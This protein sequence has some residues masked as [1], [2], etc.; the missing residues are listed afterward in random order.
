MAQQRGATK[1]RERRA[2]HWS[3][4]TAAD[5]QD[6]V[7]KASEW[8]LQITRP[9]IP[10]LANDRASD[11]LMELVDRSFDSVAQLMDIQ[12]EFIKAFLGM[13]SGPEQV[14]LTTTKAGG[15]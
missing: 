10:A 13:A 12:R 6:M 9:F 7:T 14:D 3:G 8:W 5:T 1:D 11:Q 2:D 15:S 4:Q